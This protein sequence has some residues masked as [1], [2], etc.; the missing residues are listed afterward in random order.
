[1]Q[2]Y[3]TI[4]GI[5]A[6]GGAIDAT[7]PVLSGDYMTVSSGYATFSQMPGNAVLVFRLKTQ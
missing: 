3:N 5:A 2:D 6:R 7:G 4:N 1:V